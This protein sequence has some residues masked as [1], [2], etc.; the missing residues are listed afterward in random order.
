M[1]WIPAHKLESA[2]VHHLTKVLLSAGYLDGVEENIAK[3]TSG[4]NRDLEVSHEKAL[5]RL[6]RI[7]LDIKKTIEVQTQ[8]DD[9]TVDEA[10]KDRLRALSDEKKSVKVLLDEIENL[11]ADSINPKAARM[12]IESRVKEFNR[13]WVKAKPAI[14]K[15]LLS[16]VFESIVLDHKGLSLNYYLD[17]SVHVDIPNLQSESSEKASG[18]LSS[19]AKILQFNKKRSPKFWAW[20]GLLPTAGR[21]GKN[22]KNESFENQSAACAGSDWAT[23]ENGLLGK[24]SWDERDVQSPKGENGRGDRIRTYDPLVPNQ[25]R[26]QTA[27]LPDRAQDNKYC[28]LTCQTTRS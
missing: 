20:G 1:N 17:E 12:A 22:M 10:F 25:M 21:H 16:E 26:Y 8:C 5:E 9:A 11:K 23:L 3:A 18:D 13:A 6:N 15:R 27:L 7:N 24:R 19:L 2:V 14:Q 4:R 28:G